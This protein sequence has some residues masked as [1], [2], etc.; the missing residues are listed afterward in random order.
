MFQRTSSPLRVLLGM[1]L[2]CWFALPLLPQVAIN[3]PSVTGMTVRAEVHHDVSPPLR[4][5]P[6]IVPPISFLHEAEPVRLLPLGPGFKPPEAPDSVHQRTAAIA[7]AGLAPTVNLGFD[8][9]GNGSLGFTVNSAPP[10]T[11][12]AVGSTQYVQWVNTSFAVFDKSTG[13]LVFGPAAGDTLWQ[14]FGGPCEAN[15]DGDPIAV[16]DKKANRWLMT[17][18][19]VTGGQFFQCVA[20]STSSDATGTYR[21]FA[22]Q[23]TAFNDYPKAGVWPD[24]YYVSFNMFNAAGTAFLGARACV[25]DRIRMIT[26]ADTP[27][28]IQCFQLGSTF[29]GLLPSDQDGATNPPAGAPNYFVAFGTNLLQLWKYHVDWAT[30]ANSTFTGPTN[31]SVAT[32]SEACGG[33][34]CIPQPS[35]TQQLDSL[36]DRLMYRLAY[37]NFGTHESLVANHSVTAGSAAS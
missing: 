32:F 6:V 28:P 9:L 33:G 29:G 36:A 23:F 5:M 26:A 25:L 20:V 37:R 7:P 2:F 22:Y 18:F 34:T 35:T 24:G 3:S 1:L 17:Q 12:G 30:P 21:R 4:D 14:G 8:G 11:N 31:V 19:S 15:N 10:D 13:A 16:Y 27:G